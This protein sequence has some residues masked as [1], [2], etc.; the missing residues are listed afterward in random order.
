MNASVT[1]NKIAFAEGMEPVVVTAM[2]GGYSLH[3]TDGYMYA[4]EG[5][6]GLKFTSEPVLNTIELD[7]DGNAII[8]CNTMIFRFNGNEGQMRF[9]YYKPTSTVQTPVQLYKLVEG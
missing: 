7:A 4:N 5:Y 9:R 2:E 1:D 8:T 6:N 3:V